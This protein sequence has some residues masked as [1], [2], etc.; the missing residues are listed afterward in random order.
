MK[1]YFYLI[2]FFLLFNCLYAKKTFKYPIG[3]TPTDV[4]ILSIK[5][6]IATVKSNTNKEIWQFQ[7]DSNKILNHVVFGS[8][9]EMDIYNK[10]FNDNGIS[11][12]KAKFYYDNNNMNQ[13]LCKI[14]IYVD[15]DNEIYIKVRGFEAKPIQEGNS[16]SNIIMQPFF[17]LVRIRNGKIIE[18]YAIQDMYIEPGYYLLED[19]D[20][21]KEGSN[22]Y[23]TIS[24]EKISESNNYF[25]GKWTNISG[26]LRFKDYV[27]VELPDFNKEQHIGYGLLNFIYKE[28]R[29]MFYS[30]PYLYNTTEN[31]V[32]KLYTNDL[33]ETSFNGVKKGDIFNIRFTVCDFYYSSTTL[34][35]IVRKDKLFYI[36]EYET[37][38]LKL[39]G[40]KNIPDIIPEDLYRF[41]FFNSNGEIV[42][43][44]KKSNT[45]VVQKI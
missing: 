20:F 7:L 42:Y 24:K 17:V 8:D 40:E 5:N 26:K 15:R 2:C 9:F 36:D 12:N 39:M 37:A 31:S 18:S 11:Y 38:T 4:S 13:S 1:K 27:D 6:N 3:I 45:I 22:F 10:Y 34:K 29:L 19:G 14:K 32:N 43:T 23:F 16:L 44:P 33:P 21:Y 30:C 41:P 28:N 25:I 35:V